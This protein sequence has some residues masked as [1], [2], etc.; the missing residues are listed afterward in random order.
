MLSPFL[1]LNR[2]LGTFLVLFLV[3]AGAL[4]EGLEILLLFWKAEGRTGI[5]GRVGD[6]GCLL[7]EILRVGRSR[8]GEYSGSTSLSTPLSS[9]SSFIDSSY[10]DLLGVSIARQQLSGVGAIFLGLSVSILMQSLSSVTS[11]FSGSAVY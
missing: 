1:L 6:R 3:G 4:W 11:S 8:E 2:L 10:S 9:S 5:L 7:F